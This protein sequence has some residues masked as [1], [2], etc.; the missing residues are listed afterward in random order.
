LHIKFF[1]DT[2][3]NVLLYADFM[4]LFLDMILK[5]AKGFGTTTQRSTAGDENSIGGMVIIFIVIVVFVASIG[6]IFVIILIV[7]IIRSIIIIVFALEFSRSA[8]SLVLLEQ[9]PELARS[10][11]EKGR[12]ETM[13]CKTK[14]KAKQTLG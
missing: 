9:R 3:D 8:G 11:K 6:I 5:R 4:G 13:K 7:V 1:A 2:G 12:R 10:L 14:T